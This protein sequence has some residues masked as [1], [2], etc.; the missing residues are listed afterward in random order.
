M[1]DSKKKVLMV[2]LVIACLGVAGV[3]T[4]SRLSGGS[5]GIDSID[6][7]EKVWLKCTDSSCGAE[8]Q[9][10]AREYYKIVQERMNPMSSFVPPVT[11]EK[12]G[13]ETCL[14]AI[15]CA[16]CGK[17]FREGSVSGDHADRCPF[18]KHSEI[19]DSRKRRASGG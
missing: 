8:F 1:E 7:D 15:K 4:V 12:C 3:V 16:N 18:C 5:G 9:M 6:A 2:V 13:K 11:C 19:E 14:K 17:V 10:S